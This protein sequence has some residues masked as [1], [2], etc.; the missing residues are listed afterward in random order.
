VRDR[1]T[2]INLV[3]FTNG[4]I[5]EIEEGWQVDG[6][7]Y[8]NFS[9]AFDRVFH[10]LLNYNL[11]I[12]FDGSLLCWMAS[13]LVGQ[14]Q[15]VKLADYFSESIQFHFRVPKGSPEYSSFW[16]S[17]GHWTSLKM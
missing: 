2:I 12:L 14:T 9:K 16:I 8:I 15:R 10:G 1:S 11:S 7:A 6:A 3:P 17:T 5:D 4:V 13:Y